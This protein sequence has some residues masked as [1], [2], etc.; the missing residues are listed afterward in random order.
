MITNAKL[1][2]KALTVQKQNQGPIASTFIPNVGESQIASGELTTIPA[3][4][5]AIVRG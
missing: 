5:L 4:A 1:E 2:K 3:A